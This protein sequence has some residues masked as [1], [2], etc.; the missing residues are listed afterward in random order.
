ML[1]N[2]LYRSNK[3]RRLLP[4]LVLT[5]S[6]CACSSDRPA[7]ESDKQMDNAPVV[8]SG[9]LSRD[10]AP[11]G[12]PIRFWITIENRSGAALQ[13]VRLAHLDTPGFK[14][15]T[16][17][18][19]RGTLNTAC[20][21]SP[22]S[23]PSCSAPGQLPHSRN[24][25]FILCD[26][27]RAGESLSVWGDLRAYDPSLPPNRLYAVVS[28]NVVLNPQSS[29]SDIAQSSKVV[30]FGTAEAVSPSLHW[31]T[32]LA[33]PEV[34]IPAA[35][36][37]LGFYLT[38]RGK[39]SEER[40]NVF[41]AMLSSVHEA[42][43]H[44]HMPMTSVL[45]AA[46]NQIDRISTVVAAARKK[47]EPIPVTHVE[48]ARRGFYYLTMFH[49]WQRR[50]FQKVGAYQLKSREGERLL[51]FLANKHRNELYPFST[52]A[53][54]RRLDVI[55][56][57]L[58]GKYTLDE[59]LKALDSNQAELKTAWDE[60]YIWVGTSNCDK[61][62]ACLDA[63]ATIMLYEVNSLHL[64]WYKG[65]QAMG[66][67]NRAREAI[68]EVSQGNEYFV[69]KVEEYLSNATSGEN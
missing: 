19:D 64:L 44:Y 31:L 7:T 34:T 50:V 62:L 38:S 47:N 13:N 68:F 15:A 27:L 60:F 67:S 37:F 12:E 48:I 10:V 2:I 3:L 29:S 57:Q 1:S 6:F 41:T 24:D 26:Y 53:A 39:K 46:I 36:A 56:G 43:M 16:E 14:S 25:E 65:P 4:F 18:W 32:W 22:G 58:N 30:S 42:A 66:L 49:W 54:L 8:I 35:L 23:G 45:S 33:K 28:W 59:F 21:V 17:C 5:T 61:D 55:L 40:N 52:E 63:F 51:L 20:G 9:H 11:E 69:R